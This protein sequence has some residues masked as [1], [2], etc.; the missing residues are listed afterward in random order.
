MSDL[1]DL[2]GSIPSA[3]RWNAEEG[4]LSV[5]TCGEPQIIELGTRDATFAIDLE[6]RERGWGLI[7]TGVYDMQLTPVGTPAP[8]RPSSDYKLALGCWLWNPKFGEIRCETL[9]TMF[10]DPL[11]GF[12]GRVRG[13]KEAEEGQVPVACFAGSC[14]RT[15]KSVGKSFVT[16]LVSLVGWI[17]RDKI[18]PFAV[19]P[20]TVPK[21]SPLSG[22]EWTLLTGPTTGSPK[23]TKPPKAPST[24]KA[25][26]PPIN[27]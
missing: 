20:P 6:T 26:A 10:R 4:V 2:E 9:G 13:A 27:R 19:R 11:V 3:L 15:I 22:A 1:S 14:E 7:R 25:V 5:W 17:P 21:A 8:D 24:A 23:V 18:P 12:F 16:P